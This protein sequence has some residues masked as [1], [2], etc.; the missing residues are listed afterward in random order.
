M[1]SAFSPNK[2]KGDPNKGRA[3][4]S[5]GAFTHLGSQSSNSNLAYGKNDISPSRGA[6]GNANGSVLSSSQASNFT[7]GTLGSQMPDLLVTHKIINDPIHTAVK[8][9]RLS[10]RI[11]DTPQYQRLRQLKQ[12]GTCS[13]VFPSA[14]HTRFEHSLGVAHLAERVTRKLQSNQ[15][16]L[17]IT[18]ADIL[19][20]KISGLCHDLG[21]GPFSHVYVFMFMFP[22]FLYDCI[23]D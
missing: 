17:G 5:S 8:L 3:S 22:S 9:D 4:S 10:C 15:P 20:V 21:H 14:G 19:A 18:D 2:K 23:L 6:R 7:H 11:V 1:A 13:F 12:L 16:E